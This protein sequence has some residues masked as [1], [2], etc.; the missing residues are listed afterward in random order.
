MKYSNTINCVVSLDRLHTQTSNHKS[1]RFQSPDEEYKLHRRAEVVA[2]ETPAP[3]STERFI[4]RSAS[5]ATISIYDHLQF[6]VVIMTKEHLTEL[7][8]CVSLPN[9]L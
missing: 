3:Y 5:N 2:G 4:E 6:E 9:V 8:L 7:K 1:F